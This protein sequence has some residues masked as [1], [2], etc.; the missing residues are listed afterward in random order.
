MTEPLQ[1]FGWRDAIDIAI[2]AWIIYRL[3]IMLR[4]RVAYRLLLV[5]AFLAAL[6]SLSRLAGF[7]AFHWIVGSLF[8]SLIL[9]L[10]ILFQ[11]DIRRALMTH[12]KHRHPLTE[13]RDEQGERDHA[14]L[15]IGELIAAATSL[16]SRRIGAL[17]VIEREMGVMSHVETGT[18]VD[19]KITSEI[20]TSIFLPYSP[21]H[22]GAVVIRHGKLM[23]AGCFLPLSQDPTINKNLGTRH[24]A[25]LGLTELVD[26]VVLVVSEETGT[27][28]VTV[29]GRILPV[30]DAVSL[31]KVL[32]KLLEPRWL[33][34]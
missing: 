21:I 28:S 1:I 18:E 5:L 29:G 4:G 33:T 23:R 13:D 22:D 11:H 12:G 19:A 16:S 14:S 6:Y 27:I 25:A 31:R 10:V 9:I 30:S 15:I 3:I 2:V 26:C 7:E 34:E 32:K 8:S 20:L 17:I 24:R